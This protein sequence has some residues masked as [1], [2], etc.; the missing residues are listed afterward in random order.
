MGFDLTFV[1]RIRAPEA[2][3]RM[4]GNL[5]RINPGRIDTVN[6]IHDAL[7]AAM[8]IARGTDSGSAPAKA[9]WAKERECIAV[10][11]DRSAMVSRLSQINDSAR[12][13]G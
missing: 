4:A 6:V 8:R 10:D 5:M 7:M 1:H 2:R 12:R 11:A 9:R 13:G 3:S